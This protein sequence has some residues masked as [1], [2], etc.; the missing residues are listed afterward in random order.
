M[1]SRRQQR[2]NGS[3]PASSSLDGAHPGVLMIQHIHM[4][5]VLTQRSFSATDRTRAA[6]LA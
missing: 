6:R 4:R 3:L 2:M 5:A 1:C